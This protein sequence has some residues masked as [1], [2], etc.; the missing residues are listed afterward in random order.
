MLNVYFIGYGGSSPLAEELRFL[1]EQ[2]LQMKLYTI[3]EWDNA[4]IKWNRITWLNHLKQAD[5]IICPANYKIQPAKS[6]NRV[7]QALSLGKPVIASPM[8]SYL[9]VLQKHP[10]SFLIADTKEE[11][12]EKL[13]VLRDSEQLRIDLSKKALIAAKDY[14]IDVITDKWL[15]ALKVNE[16]VDI[17]IP[18][19]K[20]L[21]GIKLC[22]D[23]IKACTDLPYNIIVVNN[24]TDEELHKYLEKR[25][26]IRYVKKP[27]MN[28][29][30][31]MNTGI[32][33][34]SSKYI[35]LMNDDIIVS[36]GWLGEMVKACTEGVGAVG[37]LSNC[38]KGWRHNYNLSIGGVDLLPGMNTFE[39]IEPAVPQIYDYKSPYQDV[40]ERD[41]TAFYCTLIPRAVINRVGLLNEDYTNSGED[42]DLCRRIKK[43]GYRIVDTYKAFVF[44]FGAVSR[45][46]LEQEDKGSY[47]TAD[48]KTNQLLNHI[49][50][51][52]SV[53][54]YSGPSWEKWNYKNVDEGGIGG[55]ETW[56]VWVARELS[57]IGYR[58]TVFADCPKSPD[59]D[60]DVEWL[61]YG[62]Y[63]KWVEQH[64]TDYFISSRTTDTLKL[65]LRAGKIYV[66]SHDIFLLSQKEQI[67]LDKV[68]KFC[69]LS[70]WHRDFLSD[71]H[72]I[73][74]D[75]IVISSNGIDFNRFD[76]INIKRNPYRL[77]YSSSADRGLDTL[78]YLFDFMK[79]EI[80]ELELHVF[81]GFENWIKS[82]KANGK[83]W[84]LKKLNE[85]QK[86]LKKPGVFYHGRVGQKE[87][88]V[89]FLKS[90]LWAYPSDFE[91][92]FC[93]T[94]LEAQRAGV[95]VLASNYA[96][97]QTTVADSGIL[98]GNGTK[99]Q[100]YTKEYRE[101]FVA[102][103]VSLLKDKEKWQE[104]SDKGFKNSEKYSWANVAL[105]W[106]KLFQEGL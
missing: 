9:R 72:K 35:L 21:R 90:S 60:G 66:L 13:T 102:G 38:D 103:A 49:W 37:P 84:E 28:F 2:E 34:G 23:S 26:D 52:E 43:C 12:K 59:H 61:H 67:F 33:A 14:S 1:I 101:K 77:I 44:H 50:G 56:V 70:E 24:G 73:P 95:P 64:W 81:Y 76:R 75:K 4:D 87:L 57:K 69:A 98:I 88:A 82:I 25:A 91:E 85:I 11:W 83:D 74:K 45:R 63:P 41:W 71:Y 36:K 53:V 20:N 86:G 96:G 106:K 92:S 15:D 80:P 3:H 68:T 16:K 93:I 10:A 29:S 78:L 46:L 104:W 89:E 27:R 48:K 65:P 19:Y 42:V 55:S 54:I 47:Q 94:A 97:L 32:Q 100:S 79:K 62:Q 18:T 105:M 99:G 5:I 40:I 51:K 58:V 6:A 39:Q 7:T 30:Q 22:L 31:G 17:I 8:D